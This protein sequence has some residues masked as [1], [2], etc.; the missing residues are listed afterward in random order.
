MYFL[1]NKYDSTFNKEL[2]IKIMGSFHN[3]YL[4]DKLT[5]SAAD[6]NH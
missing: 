5:F 1:C 4:N 6:L 3:Q 2:T